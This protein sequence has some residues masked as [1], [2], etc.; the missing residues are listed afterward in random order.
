MWSISGFRLVATTP[1]FA[2]PCQIVDRLGDP[3]RP[4]IS[5]MVARNTDGLK[6]GRFSISHQ[7][8]CQHSAFLARSMR[9]F[10]GGSPSSAFLIIW[11]RV[12][13]SRGFHMHRYWEAVSPT[14]LFTSSEEYPD[15]RTI[16]TPAFSLSKRLASS[17][18]LSPGITISIRARSIG[19]RIGLKR[20]RA[21]SP[22]EAVKTLNPARSNV[23]RQ[24]SKTTA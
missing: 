20:L 19:D 7:A 9:T 12:R 3:P 13:G 18:P 6:Y 5:Y 14:T 23:V 21:W 8:A 4:R 2:R 11:T 22:L 24:N 16:R 1:D 10:F 17:M 15:I